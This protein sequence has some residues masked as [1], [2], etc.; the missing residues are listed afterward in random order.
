M[1]E[2]DARHWNRE[3]LVALFYACILTQQ[4]EEFL[5]HFKVMNSLTY[6]EPLYFETYSPERYFQKPCHLSPERYFQKPCHLQPGKIFSEAMPLTARK[7]IFRS[8]ATASS[9]L[10]AHASSQ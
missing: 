1:K 10:F 8:H 6:V 4:R 5:V 2:Q 7:D 3:L 9:A